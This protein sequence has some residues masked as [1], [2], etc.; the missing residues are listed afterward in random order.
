[1]HHVVEGI[2][3]YCHIY[4]CPKKTDIDMSK[5]WILAFQ[6]IRQQKLKISAFDFQRMGYIES[7]GQR[8]KRISD[9]ASHSKSPQRPPSP[10]NTKAKDSPKY[11]FSPKKQASPGI[12][13]QQNQSYAVS[14]SNRLS[15][16]GSSSSSAMKGEAR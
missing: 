12:Q 2:K 10:P 3:K 13:K 7:L 4:I 1:M 11:M 5:F 14:Q 6:S 8:N 16:M 9:S 15:K